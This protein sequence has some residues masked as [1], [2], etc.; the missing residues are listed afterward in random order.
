M[1]HVSFWQHSRRKLEVFGRHVRDKPDTVVGQT[2][3][4]TVADQGMR[5]D[6]DDDRS[7]ST[8]AHSLCGLLGGRQVDVTARPGDKPWRRI[9]SMNFCT[10]LW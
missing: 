2:K 10:V 5:L 1:P 8:A 6:G 4:K 7:A 3:L 9:E